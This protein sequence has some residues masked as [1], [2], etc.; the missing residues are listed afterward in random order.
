M[1]RR[2][3]RNPRQGG[4]VSEFMDELRRQKDAER[5]SAFDEIGVRN[6]FHTHRSVEF[7]EVRGKLAIRTRHPSAA[8]AL[9]DDERAWHWKPERPFKGRDR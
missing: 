4:G 5:A 9:V 6:L 1:D 3:R 8:R 7:V 2:A